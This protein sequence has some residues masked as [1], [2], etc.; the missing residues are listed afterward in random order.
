MRL[1]KPTNH[2]LSSSLPV[3]DKVKALVGLF[4][5]EPGDMAAAA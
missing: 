5:V 2:L 4:G 3:V 1:T